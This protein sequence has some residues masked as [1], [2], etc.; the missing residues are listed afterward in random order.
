M[1]LRN[2]KTELMEWFSE[3]RHLPL[4]SGDLSL[5]PEAST[6]AHMHYAC[7]HT[8]S[9]K[10]TLKKEQKIELA[11]IPGKRNFRIIAMHQS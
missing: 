8:I 11:N 1:V 2:N 9:A 5:I 6:E 7:T 3:L 4:S 10:Q